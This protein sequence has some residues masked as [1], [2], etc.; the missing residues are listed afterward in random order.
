MAS[1]PGLLTDWP[2]KKLGSFKYGFL[3][4]LVAHSFYSFATKE[5]AERDVT[6]FLVL[7]FLLSRVL[8]A[9]IWNLVSRRLTAIEKNRIVDKEIDLDQIARE[10]DWDE[11]ILM[12]GLVL[13]LGGMMIPGASK[14]SVY[15]SDGIIITVLLHAGP[16]EFVYYWFHRALHHHYLYSRYHSHHHASIV[17]QPIS[18]VIHPFAEHIAYFMLFGT[19]IIATILSGTASIVSI[20][21]YITYIDLMN[22]MGHCNFEFV[23]PCLFSI[24]P[25]LKFM[26]YTPSYHSLHHTQFRTNYALFMPL[27]DYI[28][29]TMDKSSDALYEAWVRRQE[30]TPDAVH[31]TTLN[32]AD[33]QQT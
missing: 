21:G 10:N 4:P 9:H 15:R 22:Y 26:F 30:E 1:N 29:G 25:L 28:Y 33:E 18:S 16:V 32:S 17:T 6:N 5:K 31:L 24:F 12:N 3:V 2:W 20:F 11:Q 14:L 27:Y 13:Y 7:P 8:H 23:P 19:P